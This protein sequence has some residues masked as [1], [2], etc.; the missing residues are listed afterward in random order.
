MSISKMENSQVEP[1][2]AQEYQTVQNQLDQASLNH[3]LEVLQGL[4]L[5]DAVTNVYVVKI[6]PS[7]KVKR[8]LK[9]KRLKV[10][11]DHKQNFKEYALPDGSPQTT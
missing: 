6:S 7:N 4:D 10:H 1:I 9:I 5:S 8:F 11:N 2:A 3:K